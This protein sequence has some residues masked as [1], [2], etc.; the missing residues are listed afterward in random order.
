MASGLPLIA[1]DCVG[2]K[3]VLKPEFGILVPQR[4]VTAMR[5]AIETIISDDALRASMAAASR[6]AALNHYDVPV[7][8]ARWRTALELMP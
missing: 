2:P 3:E 7:I 1:M 8:A 5:D 4:N 6:A